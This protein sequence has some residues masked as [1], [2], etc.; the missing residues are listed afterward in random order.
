MEISKWMRS[1]LGIAAFNAAAETNYRDRL[2]TTPIATAL[3]LASGSPT[4]P[5]GLPRRS[6]HVE[7]N[8]VHAVR[9]LGVVLAL[10][11]AACAAPAPDSPTPAPASV[12]PSPASTPGISRDDAVDVAREALRE[13]GDDWRV[14][15]VESG[16]LERIMPRWREYEWGRG[17]AADL[18]VWHV[19][20]V[21]GE[22][23]GEVLIDFVDGSVYGSVVGIAN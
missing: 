1:T 13:V 21:A 8:E 7:T 14:V 9:L 16:A 18:P 4:R 10:V 20:M 6:R 19:V 22:I 11:L 5:F 17:L 12:S 3:A 23:N 2:V 15:R